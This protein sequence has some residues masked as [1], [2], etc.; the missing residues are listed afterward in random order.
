VKIK[1]HRVNFG[2]DRFSGLYLLALFIA[3]FGISQPGL[4]L[5]MG[6][7]HSIASEQAV[8]ALLGLAVVVP[9]ATGAFDLSI[10]ATAN[11]SAV[12][13]AVLQSQQH[14]SMWPAIA[15]ALGISVLIGAVN[16]FIIVRLQVNAFIATLGMATI[17]GAV[18]TIVSGNAQPLPPT[19]SAWSQ[20]TQFQIFGFQA[21]F[22]YVIIIALVSW[23]FLEWTPAGRYMYATGGN[24]VAARLSG[25]RVGAWT[26]V[27]LLFS[28]AVAGLAG[29]LF[30]SLNGPSLTFGP[31]LLLPAY[32]AA[33]LGSTQL[34]PG[35]FNVWG[36][37]LAVYVLAVGVFGVQLITSVQWLNDMFNGI[38]LIVAVSFAV[39]RQ[40]RARA[41][42]APAR[43][44][45]SASA[46]SEPGP[47][48]GVPHGSA[49]G[50][51]PGLRGSSAGDSAT[52][53]S[54]TG[55]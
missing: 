37:V 23:W 11:L 51:A 12:V 35:R 50:H 5:T 6:T 28:G 14:W 53:A 4:F 13:V 16:G 15:I 41:E 46:G 52:P 43:P 45:E 34:R 26:W 38:A 20:L 24:S 10:G 27:S 32:A 29:I 19:S 54:D 8:V 44:A 42:A 21:V 1:G 2:F 9:L 47:A 48:S 18:E 3:I 33:F 30:S 22:F 36:T 40:R 7:V 25:V 49:N 17:V 31:A 39:W 55:S